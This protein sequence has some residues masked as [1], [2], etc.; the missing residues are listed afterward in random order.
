MVFNCVGIVKVEPYEAPVF[1]RR[2][3]VPLEGEVE[4]EVLVRV[5]LV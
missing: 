1:A 2:G 3:L 5:T 4:E